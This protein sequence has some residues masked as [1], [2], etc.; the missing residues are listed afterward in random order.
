MTPIELFLKLQVSLLFLRSWIT[1]ING[2]NQTR[3]KTLLGVLDTSYLFS[4]AFF[5]FWSGLVAERMV[6]CDWW[7]GGHVTRC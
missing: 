1:E 3:A 2:Q 7:R 4:Y 5:M 6:S